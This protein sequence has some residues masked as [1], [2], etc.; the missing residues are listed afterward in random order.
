MIVEDLYFTK[1]NA[2]LFL[3]LEK[4]LPNRTSRFEAFLEL[5]KAQIVRCKIHPNGINVPVGITY[6]YLAKKWNWDRK[7]VMSFLKSLQEMGVLEYKRCGYNMEVRII[8]LAYF[9]IEKRLK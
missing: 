8:H 3:F 9:P 5:Y 4:S 6:D 7:T 2:N 1:L